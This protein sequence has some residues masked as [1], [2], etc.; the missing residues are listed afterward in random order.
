[1]SSK[2]Y[3]AIIIGAGHNGLTNAAFLAKAGLDVLVLEKN[4]YIGGATVSRELFEGWKYSNCSYVCSLFRPEIYQSLDLGRHGLEVVPL[5]GST[6]FKQNG[7]YFGS[8]H[9]GS[10]RRRE[11]ARHSKR[12][13]D[14]S[15]RFDA[16]LM[17]WCRLIRGFLLR[18]PPNPTSFKPRDIMEF[19]HLLKSFYSLSETQ[20]YE[21]MRFF[22]MSIAEYLAEYFEDETIRAHFSGGSIIGTGLGVF[23]PGTAYVLLHH[24]MGD[25]DGNVGSWGFARGGMGSV[26]KAIASSYQSMGGEVRT[27]AEVAQINVKNGTA[28]GVILASG[29]EVNART[30]V[31]N[32]D[33]KRTFL[34]IMDKKDLPEKLVHRAERFKIR[35]SSGKVN[36]ALDG[37][38]DFSALPKGS[39]LTLGH[40]HFTDTPERLERAYDDWKDDRWSQDPYLDMVIPSQYDPT[41]AP[42]GKHMVSVFVQYCPVEAEG[43]WTDDK[44]DAFGAAV[45]NQIS[46]YSPNFKDLILH[47]EIR[48]PREIEAEAGLTEGNIFQ[49]ELSLDQL[50]FNRPFPGYAQYRGPVKNMYMCSSSTHPGGGVMGAPG[51]NSAREILS[52][53]GRTDT[54]PR[55]FGDD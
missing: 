42:P 11:I 20:I 40:M 48:T 30:V 1:M 7:D 6:T 27:G 38:P 10:V 50:M 39:P 45:I 34:N 33:A 9:H 52:D 21:F 49:G 43:G 22:T 37:M 51:A 4:D 18:T 35:G 15:I 55:D 13:A 8:Y 28:T 5:Q 3:D 44:R 36:I 25:V 32:L 41:V 26:A 46:E 2:Q 24:A 12:D 16:D 53:L 14:A 19:T 23:S 47:A 31:S 17:K 29:E 54:T